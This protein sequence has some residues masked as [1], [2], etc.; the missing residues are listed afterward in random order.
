[1]DLLRKR[2]RILRN[3]MTEAERA[4]WQVLRGRQLQ[5]FRFRR[6]VPVA[7]FVADFLCPQAKLIVEVDGGQHLRAEGYDKERTATLQ[8]NGYRVLR[9]WNHDVLMHTRDV[10]DVIYRELTKGFTPP[11][12]SPSLRERE[13]EDQE[14]S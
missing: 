4:L 12:P 2:A 8:E 1:L 14:G 9:F 13:G 7:G 5:G 3:D 10:A 6:Q 11:R